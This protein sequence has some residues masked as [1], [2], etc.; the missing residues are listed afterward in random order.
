MFK[1][2]LQNDDL[3]KVYEQISKPNI[4]KPNLLKIAN[5]VL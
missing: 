2:E 1:T 5:N 3:R 4:N